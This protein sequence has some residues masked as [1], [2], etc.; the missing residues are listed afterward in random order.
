MKLNYLSDYLCSLGYCCVYNTP[1]P[2]V[3]YTILSLPGSNL[4]FGTRFWIEIIKDNTCTLPQTIV[5]GI[6][7]PNW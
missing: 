1:S 2:M 7:R 3:N 5:S 4:E 6:I